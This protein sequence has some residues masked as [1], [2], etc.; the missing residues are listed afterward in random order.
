MQYEMT[1]LAVG[2]PVIFS[3][4]PD[5]PRMALA[6]AIDGGIRRETVAGMARLASRLLLKGTETRSAEALALEL[7][8]R[9]IDVREISLTDCSLLVAVFLTRELPA[10]LDILSDVLFHS[11]FVDCSKEMT[12]LAGD[13]RASLDLP[14]EIAHDLLIQALFTGH[15][16]GNSGMRMLEEMETLTQEQVRDWHYVGLD[17]RRMNVTLV[18]DFTMAEVLPRLE[19]A[20]SG[21][22]PQSPPP[23]VPQPGLNDGDRVVTRTRPD[24]QQAQ[25]YQGWYA[26]Q[27]GTPEHAPLTVMNTILGAGGLSSRLFT[28]LRDKQG[29]AYSVRSQYLAM[30]LAG[31]F[32]VTIGTSPENI[33]R[34]R[35]GFAEQIGRM[36]QESVTLGELQGAKGRLSG[37]FV[38]AHETTSQRCLDMAINQINGLGP[39]FSEVLLQR[40][41][42]VTVADVQLAAQGIRPPSVTAIVAPEEALPK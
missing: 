18:G 41:E 32:L 21:L 16:Y 3:P 35:L 23:F 22:V 30:R 20:F 40:I 5:T 19:D 25:V 12:R 36:Q 8:E 29:L 10:V 13:I 17:P 31:E 11:T 42:G 24:A 37:S 2:L 15:P 14:S 4:V 7:D 28:E 1:E 39:D 9:A 38:L 33:E 27:A 6:V 26:P 34:A